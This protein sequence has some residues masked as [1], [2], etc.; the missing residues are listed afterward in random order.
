MHIM[1]I[2]LHPLCHLIV[3]KLKGTEYESDRP[4]GLYYGKWFDDE[5]YSDP[6]GVIIISPGI[7]AAPGQE[8]V[9]SIK[10]DKYVKRE[11]RLHEIRIRG[12]M[13][14]QEGVDDLFSAF[15]L[16][17]FLIYDPSSQLITS[18]ITELN[19]QCFECW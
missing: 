17:T 15:P 19:S 18:Y 12:L 5:G 4:I 13:V 9:W 16:N 6:S 1:S 8:W 3:F 11:S 2:D 10:E 14:Y 7:H